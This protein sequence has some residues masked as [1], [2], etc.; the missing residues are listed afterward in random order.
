MAS[1]SYYHRYVKHQYSFPWSERQKWVKLL[2]RFHITFASDWTVVTKSDKGLRTSEAFVLSEH[3]T[4]R[5]V[6][7]LFSED[8]K[9][10]AA[11]TPVKVIVAGTAFFGAM[12]L[13]GRID[14]T[15]LPSSPDGDVPENVASFTKIVVDMG[16][17]VSNHF[18]NAIMW[19]L[20]KY[21]KNPVPTSW[22]PYIIRQMREAT[23]YHVRSLYY[24][25]STETMY[26]LVRSN[27]DASDVMVVKFSPTDASPAADVPFDLD[28]G[29]G[30]G[31]TEEMEQ[32]FLE[33]SSDHALDPDVP[34]LKLLAPYNVMLV[35]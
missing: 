4:D 33:W 29:F 28:D 5:D 27:A 31:A 30:A 1:I 25:P 6:D 9:T 34:L 16:A 32:D 11:T 22:F 20:D 15:K 8:N 13:P 26:V 19:D 7:K 12:P 21:V 14:W 17:I 3:M 23:F 18:D 35:D 2:H 10:V 24:A